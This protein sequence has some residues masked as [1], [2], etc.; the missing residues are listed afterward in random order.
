[1]PSRRP[2]IPPVLVD[3]TT[4]SRDQ[5]VMLPRRGPLALRLVDTD[6]RPRLYQRVSRGLAE[7]WL[8]LHGYRI[9]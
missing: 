1:M 2:M 6:G 7:T 4:H 8:R 3:L 9:Q 5:P